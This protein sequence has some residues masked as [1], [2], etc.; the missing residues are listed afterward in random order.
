MEE[1]A[2]LNGLSGAVVG[3]GAAADTDIGIDD[4]LVFAL[5]DC[6]D[7]AVV[8]AGAALDTSVS[9][10]VSHD[11]PSIICISYTKQVKC[12]VYLYSNTKFRKCNSFFICAVYFF[13]TVAKLT[14]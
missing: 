1:S 9:D 4:E 12:F 14:G 13:V 11:I 7:G 5:G 2:F 8:G 6:F 10:I 3:A